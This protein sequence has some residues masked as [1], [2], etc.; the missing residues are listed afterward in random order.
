MPPCRPSGSTR[1]SSSA[2]SST[3]WTTRSRRCASAHDGLPASATRDD[4]RADDVGRGHRLARIVVGDDGP[5]L[6]E[7]D[8]SKLFLPYYSTKGRDSGL[9]LAIV[10]RI[11]VE[12]GGTIEASDRAP[13]GA[14]FTME[15]PP[16][17]CV[18]ASSSSTTKPASGP[19]C[20]ACCATRAS[21]WTPCRRARP[22]SRSRRAAISTSSCSTSGC[23][24]STACSRCRACATGTWM[25]PSS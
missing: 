18:P 6:G 13:H 12:H 10:R 7:A 8:R 21:K 9:G 25:P 15:L 17:P 5:G 16:A 2:W 3:W 20:R 23:R 22:V 24:A 19:P 11:I 1:S 4:Q 14:A